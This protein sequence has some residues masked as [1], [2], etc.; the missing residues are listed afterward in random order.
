MRGR[1]DEGMTMVELVVAVL[2]LGIIIVPISTSVIIGL[3]TTQRAEQRTT[4]TTDQQVLASYFVNDIQSADTVSV[5]TA[6]CSQSNVVL[7]L[8]WSDPNVGS[9]IAKTVVYVKTADEQLQRVSCDST[10]ATKTVVTVHA[11]GATPTV[12]C[13]G[14]VVACATALPGS[15]PRVVAMHVSTIGTKVGTG[16]SYETYDFDLSATRRATP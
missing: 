11:L 1:S 7:Q 5:G 2:V 4:D 10:G 15:K 3:A 9:S 8:A 16:P 13:D 6:G 12:T 14:T